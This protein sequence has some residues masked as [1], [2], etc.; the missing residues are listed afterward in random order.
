MGGE[1]WLSQTSHGRNS[2]PPGVESQCKHL[3]ES[4]C[5]KARRSS[6]ILKVIEL[7]ITKRAYEVTSDVAREQGF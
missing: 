6:E 4:A 2:T 3:S 1:F 7:L 5:I